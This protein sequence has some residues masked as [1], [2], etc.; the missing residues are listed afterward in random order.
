MHLNLLLPFSHLGYLIHCSRQCRGYISH[1]LAV[2]ARLLLADLVVLLF[3]LSHA[4]VH[5][6]RSLM[7][8]FEGICTED[9]VARKIKFVSH[10]LRLGVFEVLELVIF[11]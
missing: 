1:L 10:R 11:Y 8:V 2:A 5:V 6:L 4:A 7:E 3:P 9:I